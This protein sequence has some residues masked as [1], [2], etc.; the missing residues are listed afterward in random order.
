MHK[1][2]GR[3]GCA[4]TFHGNTNPVLLLKPRFQQSI[5]A[6]VV[7]C[8]LQTLLKACSTAARKPLAIPGVTLYYFFFKPPCFATRFFA[9]DSVSTSP[10]VIHSFTR[11][12]RAVIQQLTSSAVSVDCVDLCGPY[13]V[14]TVPI[15]YPAQ[16]HARLPLPPK[17]GL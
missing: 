7:F 6:L 2:S 16:T 13:Q 14:F 5:I 1:A 10:P 4:T 12:S 9:L 17:P 3:P 11:D 8:L 15:F